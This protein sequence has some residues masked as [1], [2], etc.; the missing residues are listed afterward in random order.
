[1]VLDELSRVLGKIE[2]DIVSIKES[3]EK[4]WDKLDKL[5]RYIVSHKVILAGIAGSV[6]LMVSVFMYWFKKKL[7]GD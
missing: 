3:Q 4:Q 6:S 1:M 5:D 2:A 7:F